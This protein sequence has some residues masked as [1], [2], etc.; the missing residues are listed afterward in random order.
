MNAPRKTLMMRRRAAPSQA[1]A[2]HRRENHQARCSPAAIPS[3]RAIRAP[4]DED[5]FLGARFLA[6]FADFFFVA[7][8]LAGTFFAT[9]FVPFRAFGRLRS[10]ARCAAAN[11]ALA[12]SVRSS[13]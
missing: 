5:L 11:A 13:G 6:F 4:L 2:S 9:G 1:D 12:Q 10:A 8:F 7:G 3:R